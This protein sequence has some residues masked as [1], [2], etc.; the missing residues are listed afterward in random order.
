MLKKPLKDLNLISVSMKINLY[1]ES[2]DF[3]FQ[4]VN[5][6]SSVAI[7]QHHQCILELVSSTVIFM[8]DL[9]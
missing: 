7:F 2:D 3:T 6:L 9:S 1:D 4:L 8:T 5:F